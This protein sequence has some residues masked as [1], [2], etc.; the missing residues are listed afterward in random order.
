[1]SPKKSPQNRVVLTAILVS[2]A[3]AASFAMS[4]A[5]NQRERYWITLNPISAGSELRAGD[6][7]YAS[8]SLGAAQSGYMTGSSN[9]T[10]SIALRRIP[11][12]ELVHRSA[13]TQNPIALTHSE[14][15]LS[16]R[17]VDIPS[18][19]S[20][21][22]LVTMYHLHDAQNGEEEEPLQR[23]LGGVFVTS[24]DRKSANFGSDVALTVSINR[25][26][27]EEVLSATTSGRIVIVRSRG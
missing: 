18:D 14:L 5:A 7:G 15:S 11:A 20:V 3:L 2:A 13:I 17:A 23:I 12:G 21:G 10:G 24:I 27:I 4:L 9:P 26:Y 22:E 8:A 16:V 19:V 1:M 25:E 6:I